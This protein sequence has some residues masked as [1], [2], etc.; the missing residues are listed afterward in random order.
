MGEMKEL[1]VKAWLNRAFYADKKVKAL[2]ML[3]EKRRE[4][5]TSVS[6]CYECNDKG[7][8]DGSKNSTEEALMMIAE[9]ELELLRN[10]RELMRIANEVSYAIAQ[11]HD[12]DLET[13]LIHRYLL[14]HKI[15]Q[16]AELMNYSVRTI[17]NKQSKAIE[18][19]CTFLPCFAP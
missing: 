3:V 18:K 9:S 12:D 10:I 1:E 17:K 5:A 15:E 4:Q 11:L 16:T 19:L 7:K 6:V 8:G 2:E 13:V 14:F